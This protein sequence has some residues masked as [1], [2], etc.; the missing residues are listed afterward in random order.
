MKLAPCI[1]QFFDPYLPD[2]RG[3]SPRTIQSYRDTFRLFLPFASQYYRIKISSLCLNH[4]SP[5][6]I[7]A[8]LNELQR[9]R[10]NLPRTRNQR[11]AAIKSFAKMLRFT[12]PE[13]R[14]LTDRILHIPQKRTQKT[15]IVIS[16]DRE[17]VGG[18]GFTGSFDRWYKGRGNSEVRN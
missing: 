2:I 9:K 16:H 5:E 11:L 10:H 4:I 12:Y 1:H 18:V 15:L 13:H 3:L 8:F 14:E 6:L 17:V 7:I